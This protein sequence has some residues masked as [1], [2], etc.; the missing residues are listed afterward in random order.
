MPVNHWWASRK[1][2]DNWQD[3]DVGG[4]INIGIGLGEIC[5]GGADW[6]DL[7]QDR[8]DWRTILNMVMNLGV[9]QN[10]GKFLSGCATCSPSK[11]PWLQTI[12]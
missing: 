11:N 1:E 2:G 4:W 9:P 6:M 5:C 10:S 7:D 8:G 12:S 3:K